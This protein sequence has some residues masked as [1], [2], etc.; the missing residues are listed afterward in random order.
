[1]HQA[2]RRNANRQRAIAIAI[3][4]ERQAHMMRK[5]VEMMGVTTLIAVGLLAL[6]S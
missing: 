3:A 6:F 5:M 4:E 2:Q 1:M